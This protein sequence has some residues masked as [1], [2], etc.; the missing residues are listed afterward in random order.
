[1][2]QDMSWFDTQQVGSLTNRMSS[3]AEKLKAGIG[4]KMGLLISALGSFISGIALGF[5][6]SWKMTLVMM[7]TVPVLLAAMIISAKMISRASKSETYAYSTAGGLANEVIS[8]IRTVM[9]FN[10]QPFEIHRY[11]KELKTARKL[12]IHKG[13]VLGVFAGLN[14]FLLFAA[15]A[16]AFWYGTT[17]VVKD[18]ISPGTV[19]AVFWAVLVGTRR[20]G[21]AIPQMGV[22]LGAKL[23]AADIFAVIDRVPDIDSSKMEGFTPEEIT[24]RLSFTNVH[25]TYPARPTV[26]ILDDVSYEVKL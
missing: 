4:D 26:K 23:A 14:V 13:V 5:Y 3:G 12:G 16:V 2:R 6:L 10:A 7:I 22:I 19:F 1:M 21:D 11:E 20:F 18:E 25:F 9:S 24:G 8:G 17:L 15:M